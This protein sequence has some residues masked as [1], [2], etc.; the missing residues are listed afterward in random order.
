[1][2]L[3]LIDGDILLYKAACA[4]EKE[5]RWPDGVWTLSANEQDGFDILDA[6]IKRILQE[7]KAE[8]YVVCLSGDKNF[9]KELMPDYKANR[10]ELRRPLLLKALREYARNNHN[11]EE[12]HNL[13]ADDVMGI[14][15]TKPENLGKCVIVTLDKDLSQIPADVYNMDTKKMSKAESREPFKL[16]MKQVLTGDVIDNFKGCPSVGPVG[17]EKLLKDVYD[18][19]A[20]WG[21][22][23]SAFE[24]AGLTVH[25]ALQQ[26][27][28]ARILQHEDYKDNQIILWGKQY[29]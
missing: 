19:D 22:V 8:D 27:R 7:L 16:F 4:A 5:M 6:Q 10:K 15:A 12:I 21:V 9:R 26:A 1:M 25:D 13:E 20:M 17:A 24:K 2:T 23:V 3:V 28:V 18:P 11:V 14:L 29:E